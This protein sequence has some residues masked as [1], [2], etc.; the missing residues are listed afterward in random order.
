MKNIDLYKSVPAIGKLLGQELPISLAFKLK[1]IKKTVEPVIQLIEESKKEI[2]TKYKL[3][4]PVIGNDGKPVEGAFYISDEG[5]KQRQELFDVEC[6]MSIEKISID[7]L[8]KA[9]VKISE[10][11]LE[12]LE[13]MIKE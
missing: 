12:S 9:E 11:D 3:E 4:K 2:E 7:E 5:A 10:V 1:N 8:T 13:W 6:N